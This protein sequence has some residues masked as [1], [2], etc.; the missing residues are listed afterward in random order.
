MDDYEDYFET[1]NLYDDT[2]YDLI[3]M[4]C[5]IMEEFINN[6]PL[7]ISEENFEDI[8]QDNV[9]QIVYSSIYDIYPQIEEEY[10]DIIIYKIISESSKIIYSHVI[11]KRFHK[12]SYIRCEAN[13]EKIQKKID[14]IR[15]IPQPE[16]RTLEWYMFRH[17]LITASN[18]YKC[19]E[20][21]KKINE[22]I[23]EKCQPFKNREEPTTIVKTDTPFH[24]GQKYEPV[25]VMIYENKYNCVI[26]DF[27]CIQHPKFSFLGA[28]PDGI[29]VNSESKRFGRMLEIKNPIS[30]IITSIPKKMYWI[31]MQLQMEVCNLHECDFLETKFVEYENAYQFKNDGTFQKTFDKKQKGIILQFNIDKKNIYE[32]APLNISETDYDTWEKEQLDK[33]LSSNYVNTIYWKLEQISCSLVLRNKLW[34]KHAVLEIEKVWDIVLKERISG[35]EH[36][37]PQKKVKKQVSQEKC[38]LNVKE[39]LLQD[40]NSVSDLSD[41]CDSKSQPKSSSSQNSI[42][43]YIRIRTQSFDESKM[44]L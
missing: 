30:R 12:Y 40:V 37:A 34:F 1:I 36:R 41:D 16:Q 20:N 10:I 23:F 44:C 2:Y 31:Q 32:Y 14:T 19:L 29:V 3:D 5:N 24:W 11:P 13:K 28:S 21:D 4:T 17:N 25:S 43:E 39:L 42:N 8:F 26:E 35:Y 22:I 18:A 7:L 9:S 27:G 6:S 15:N 33:H 38:L